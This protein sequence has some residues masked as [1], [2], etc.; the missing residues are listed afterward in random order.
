MLESANKL[1]ETNLVVIKSS[2][3][4]PSKPD[5]ISNFSF[6]E[7]QNY[8]F[9]LVFLV[10][11]A[12][13][14]Y[15][16]IPPLKSFNKS[17]INKAEK[18]Y[19]DVFGEEEKKLNKGK[20]SKA[21]LFRFAKKLF[22]SANHSKDSPVLA[23]LLY[24][25]ALHYSPSDIQGLK[26]MIEIRKSQ[27]TESGSEKEPYLI[28]LK[29]TYEK[30]YPLTKG[31]DRL[32]N[33]KELIKIELELADGFVV[34]NHDTQAIQ[35]LNRIKIQCKH[36]KLAESKSIISDVNSRF[37]SINERK[38]K[39]DEIKRLETKIKTYPDDP[40]INL[41]YAVYLLRKNQYQEAIAHLQKSDFPEVKEVGKLLGDKNTNWQQLGD[42]A[43]QASTRVGKLNKSVFVKI[44]I[45][46]YQRVVDENP[47]GTETARLKLIITQLGE[48]LG[49]DSES[50]VLNAKMTN[51]L[52][53][54]EKILE[55]F[56]KTDGVGVVEWIS[57][58][59][60]SNKGFLRIKTDYKGF[61]LLQGKCSIVEKPEKVREWR[62][63][64]LLWR[65]EGTSI[66][67]RLDIANS[68]LA[69]SAVFSFKSNHKIPKEWQETIIDLYNE[70]K[71]FQFDRILF[72]VR[73]DGKADYQLILLGKS[74]LA[75]RQALR[76]P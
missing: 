41:E 36:L 5:L 26:L 60:K 37:A 17:E 22:D 38:K 49:K 54:P 52:K 58:G 18:I 13:P 66:D 67:F 6:R 59:G 63:L 42:S 7:W 4:G 10:A 75:V 55:N 65:G 57:K 46:S 47:T 16:K 76:N 28:L 72:D 20:K 21:D 15:G 23:A 61:D 44:A 30:L 11:I 35:Y 71:E 25:R 56:K 51:L 27:L 43:R 1:Y 12:Y 53:S 29:E 19:E 8:F 68:A 73:P 14:S 70:K 24:E 34:E 48:E 69:S 62:Y 40:K 33:L 2:E 3:I 32:Q 39:F 9:T 74:E 50:L 31:E 45:Q 64:G